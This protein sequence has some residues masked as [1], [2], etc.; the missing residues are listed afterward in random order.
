[1]TSLR[2]Y[3][4][5]SDDHGR[6][7]YVEYDEFCLINIYVPNS[8]GNYDY[9]KEWD[10]KLSFDVQIIPFE[11]DLDWIESTLEEIKALLEAKHIPAYSEDETCD[12]CRNLKENNNLINSLLEKSLKYLKSG[13]A[14]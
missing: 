4:N 12:N 10:N 13:E 11:V 8:G 1:M 6:F 2:Q 14:E 9:R 5:F 3:N 7:I